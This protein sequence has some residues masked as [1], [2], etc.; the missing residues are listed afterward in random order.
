MCNT[1]AKKCNTSAKSEI[2][3]QKVKYQCKLHIEIL[4]YDWL[5]NDTVFERTNQIFGFQIK[6]VPNGWCNFM[7]QFFPDW[8]VHVRFFCLT[9]SNF[10][11]YVI[12]K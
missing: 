4:D 9:I 7:T 5:I 11:M 3:V 12:N 10:F 6:H 8:V 2:P 1:S